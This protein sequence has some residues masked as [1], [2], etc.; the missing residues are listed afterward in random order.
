L[1]KEDLKRLID[2][3]T[4]AENTPA[5]YCGYDWS[6]KAWGD[7]RRYWEELG[8]KYKFNPA[9]IKGIK[10]DTGEVLL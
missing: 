1:E 4:K 3:T 10:Q 8:K 2:L 9:Q 6:K 7:V 5:I